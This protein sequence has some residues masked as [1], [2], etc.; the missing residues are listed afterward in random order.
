M[1]EKQ[2]VENSDFVYIVSFIWSDKVCNAIYILFSYKQL[3]SKVSRKETDKN[4]EASS[5]WISVIGLL[6]C[7]QP[8]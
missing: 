4:V 8:S 6:F 3:V 5:F 7:S 2:Y 1:H